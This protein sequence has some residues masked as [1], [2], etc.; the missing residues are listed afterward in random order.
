MDERPTWR[1]VG[2]AAA[3]LEARDAEL[4][5]LVAWLPLVPTAHLVPFS[6][7]GPRAVDR[8]VARLRRSGLVA[9]VA[10]PS[11]GVG[12]RRL[13]LLPT[14]LGLAVLAWRRGVEP[15]SLA[16]ARDLHRAALRAVIAELPAL[17]ASYALL[18]LLAGVGRRPA[19]LRAWARPWRW[20]GPSTE[21]RPGRRLR[22]PAYAALAWG[23]AGGGQQQAGY[24]LVPDTGG[25]SPAAL[26]PKLAELARL[27]RTTELAVPG[28]VIATTS[29]QRV[30]AWRVLLDQVAASRRGGPC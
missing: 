17:L 13:L 29:E 24:L 1:A 27:G 21:G 23:N 25:L 9:A 19:R 4:L 3:S 14:N 12:R 15:G 2:H 10:G 30:E 26:R 8:C 20:R 28:V 16:R 18:A 11:D 22:L 7:D 6:P 5:D